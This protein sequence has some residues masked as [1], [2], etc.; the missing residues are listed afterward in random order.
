MKQKRNSL[1]MMIAAGFAAALCAC[2]GAG[3]DTAES[4]ENNEE[5]PESTAEAAADSGI[6]YLALVNKLNKLPDDWE[7]RLETEH[8]T[9]SAGDDVEVETKA[10]DA[11]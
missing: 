5:T 11:Y 10:Y 6:D 2:S 8:M 7:S 3:T 4:S 9:N 1:K